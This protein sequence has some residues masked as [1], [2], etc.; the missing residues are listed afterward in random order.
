MYHQ[1]IYLDY[2]KHITLL[3]ATLLV[4]HKNTDQLHKYLY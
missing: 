1:L 2:V 3:S 4:A